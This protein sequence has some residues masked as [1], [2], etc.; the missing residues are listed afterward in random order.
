MIFDFFK[1]FYASFL[2]NMLIIVVCIAGIPMK[3][4]IR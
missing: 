1:L 4:L 2:I 3:V